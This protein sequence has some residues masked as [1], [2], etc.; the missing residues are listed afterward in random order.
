[1]KTKSVVILLVLAGITGIVAAFWSGSGAGLGPV[2]QGSEPLSSE[3]RSLIFVVTFV[4]GIGAIAAA[5]LIK[6]FS[7]RVLGAA[8]LLF[9]ASLFPSILQGNVLSIL[10]FFILLLVGMT[11]LMRRRPPE[12]GDR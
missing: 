3:T 5:V 9:A 11:L 2:P 12:A 10:S 8:S 7:S 1:M 4:G 6:T